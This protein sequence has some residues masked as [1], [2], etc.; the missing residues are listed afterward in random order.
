MKISFHDIYTINKILVKINAS[1]T[2]NVFFMHEI[3]AL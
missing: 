1:E 2:T 3:K